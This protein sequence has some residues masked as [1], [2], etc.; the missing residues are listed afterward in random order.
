MIAVL[1]AMQEER[2]AFLKMMDNAEKLDSETIYYHQRVL[3]NEYY[4][5]KINGKDVVLGR[6]GVGMIYATINTMLMIQK[7]NP[8][9]LINCGVAG[10]L[11]ENI[12]VRDIVVAN[13]T[14]DWRMD[15][16]GWDRSINSDKFSFACDERVLEI[17]SDNENINVGAILSANEFIK[18]KEQ[19]EIIKEFFPEALAGEMEG[20]AV[21]N[22][23][24]ALGKKCSIIRSISDETLVQ[25]NFEQF[26]FNLQENCDK[27]A[28]LCKEIIERY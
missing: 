13:R 26:D 11:N 17:V 14:A 18:D 22:T 28:A 21:A 24:Y 8:E 3:D 10:S 27:V 2:D 25:N 12:H 1:C 4:I 9:L 20:A 7:F 23:C 16:P 19:L 6:C 5:G 15:V